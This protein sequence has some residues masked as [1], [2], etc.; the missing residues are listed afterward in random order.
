MDSIKKEGKYYTPQWVAR[1][2]HRKLAELF[3]DTWHEDF[4]VW[5]C[6]AG[7]GNLFTGLP[8]RANYIAS[9]IDPISVIQMEKRADAGE[10]P[11]MLGRILRQD[12]L[13]DIDPESVRCVF[14][15][16]PD[17]SNLLFLVNPPYLAGKG[18]DLSEQFLLKMKRNYRGCKI[19]CFTKPLW[20]LPSN[21]RFTNEFNSHLLGYVENGLV[22]NS[23]N[24]GCKGEFPIL[25]TV[26]DTAGDCNTNSICCRVID[27]EKTG[28]KEFGIYM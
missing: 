8:K 26:W 5:D 17:N 20:S 15:I 3:G 6:A 2:A 22:F 27:D 13:K 25:F 1:I 21:R 7:T 23:K 19:A 11:V 14:Q 18:G 16:E 9:D 4:V 24:F 28:L 12:F 10:L